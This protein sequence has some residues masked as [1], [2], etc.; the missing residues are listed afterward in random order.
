MSQPSAGSGAD[1]ARVVL[2][3]APELETARKL[4]RELVEA[5]AA[6]CANIVPGLTS[7][8]RWQGAIQEDQEVLLIVKARADKLVELE[9]IVAR[10]HPYEVPEIVALH[11]ADVE[12]RYLG[13]WIAET[14][15]AAR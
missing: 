13:W 6:A 2:I 4:A 11:P 10:V 1:A 14:G 5:R 8:Y 9:S 7:I 15:G 3:T 12:R